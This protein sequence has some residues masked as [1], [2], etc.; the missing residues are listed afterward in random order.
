MSASKRVI[1]AVASAALATSLLLPASVQ[2]AT[3]VGLGTHGWDPGGGD[4]RWTYGPSI[5]WYYQPHP[6]E[7]FAQR[8]IVVRH[9]HRFV[10]WR[11]VCY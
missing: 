3:H 9:G 8:R 5:A 11:R 10:R 4:F 1:V 2:A 6:V 7:C